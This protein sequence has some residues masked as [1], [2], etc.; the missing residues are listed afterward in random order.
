MSNGRERNVS[1]VVQVCAGAFLGMLCMLVACSES[2]DPGESLDGS[3]GMGGSPSTSTGGVP[4]TVSGT[5]SP[6][7]FGAATNGVI[8]PGNGCGP[9]KTCA[10]LGWECGYTLD[11]CGREIDC[12][13]EGL[14]C[15]A[16]QL[17]SGAPTKC[18]DRPGP[19]CPVCDGLP[20]CPDE[21]TVTRLEGRVVTPGRTDADIGNQLGVPNAVVYIPVNLPGTTLPA[22]P[23]GIPADG[24]SCDRC[25]D[26]MLGDVLVGGIT[27]ATG[28]FV[29]E[30]R[31]P[32]GIDFM[33]V[34]KVGRFRRVI[35]Y[36]LPAE[37]ACTTTTLPTT[38]PDNPV[39]LPRSM[40]DGDQ[41]NIPRIAV[42]TGQVDAMECVLEKMGIDHGEFSNP[43]DG[44]ASTARVHLYQGADGGTFGGPGGMGPG[45]MGPGGFGATTTGA[46]TTTAGPTTTGGTT[47][48]VATTAATG[49]TGGTGMGGDGLGARIDDTTSLDE[50]LYGDISRIFQYDI[51]VADCEGIAWDGTFTERDASGGNVREFVN[52]GGRMFASHL[53]FSWL[54]ENGETAYSADD[55]LATGLGPAA[56]WTT[57]T[58]TSD[59]GE[60]VISLDRPNASPRI[61]TF[62][63]WMSNEGIAQDPDY[64]FPIIEPRSQNTG[65]G[66]A[67]EEFV[68]QSDGNERV[69][70]F[71]FDT[72]YGAPEGMGCGRVAYSGFH[73]SVGG[74]DSPF[75]DV[76]F[77]EHCMGDLTDQ[78]KVLLFMLFDLG[79]CV[80]EV[81]P[82]PPC[83]PLTCAELDT[84]GR[85]ADG[86]G[87]LLDCGACDPPK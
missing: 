74:G 51:V 19:D 38:L 84:C 87:N 28:K 49:T 45:G 67:T 53:S 65:L 57:Q 8:D 71:S 39:R 75:A 68:Y 81:P 30:G 80:G 21:A 16:N 2:S 14:V 76:I 41:V 25:E 70:Q 43:G 36:Q 69:Q 42:S 56:D 27:D 77:P 22:I 44:G 62:A 9:V 59:E 78:E 3:G 61:Q 15:G 64:T 23:T 11:D 29:L 83:V 79:A 48:A 32:V 31:I 4:S 72:P 33:L 55:P 60:G 24:T 12:E 35:T 82:S 37:A 46:G 58:D 18:V 10:E 54:Y 66:D 17:C 85:A 50:E 20:T 1:R 52:R 40:S 34:V 13:A 6:N 47:G 7:Q 86:C 26:Q 5:T 73:V 63:D